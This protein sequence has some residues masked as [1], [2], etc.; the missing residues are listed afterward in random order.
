MR[1]IFGNRMHGEKKESELEDD[2]KRRPWRSL[3]WT[4]ESLGQGGIY[5]AGNEEKRRTE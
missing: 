2:S 1:R 5:K 3:E 4:R